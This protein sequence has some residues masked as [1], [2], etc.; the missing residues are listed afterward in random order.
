MKECFEVKGYDQTLG[1]SMFMNKPANEDGSFVK[2]LKDLGAVPFC[3]TNVP[4][5]MKSYG[6]S[7]P[8]F[9]NTL[10]PEGN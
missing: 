4:Q 8:I 7:N 2:L 1:L 10:H 9:G 3:L 6:C 5:T